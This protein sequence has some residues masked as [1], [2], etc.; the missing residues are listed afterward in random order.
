MKLLK[1][2]AKTLSIFF[3]TI[4]ICIIYFTGELVFQS[5]M[6]LVNNRIT[7]LSN[8][9]RFLE[10]QGFRLADFE[11]A[12]SPRRVDVPSTFE[13]RSIPAQLLTA[14]GNQ[15]G[16]TM[17]VVH[18]LGS[19]R[20]MVYPYTRIFLE[21]GWNV[22]VYDQRSSGENTA[23]YTTYGYWESRDLQDCVDYIRTLVGPQAQVG[24]W[25]ISYGGATAGI[26]S[27]SQ[28]A[29]Q[30]DFILLDSP[31][32]SLKEM[33]RAQLTDLDLGIPVEFLLFCG[34][35]ITHL[36]LGFAYEDADVARAV[37]HTTRPIM[38]FTSKADTLTPYAMAQRIFDAV[39][40]ERKRLFT[41]NDSAHGNIM[42][43]HY[44]AYKQAFAEFLESLS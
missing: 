24:V 23:P 43:E 11:A 9:A 7:S 17:V 38:I 20:L 14:P 26:Y 10:H 32:G 2:L 39:P 35:I 30:V 12:Y 22:L 42:G 13:E 27:G 40:H 1:L 4:T 28:Q 18:G 8:A 25:G 31:V 3:I 29:A 15:T 21:Q 37:R 6:Q 44:D 19:N 36:R 16:N 33:V 34:G 5:T 41:V